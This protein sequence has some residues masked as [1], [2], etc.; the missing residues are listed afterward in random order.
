MKKN[1]NK[2]INTHFTT[3]L[4]FGTMPENSIVMLNN[5]KKN[6]TQIYKIKRY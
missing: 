1:K 6:S 3:C 4:N 2:K 5:W